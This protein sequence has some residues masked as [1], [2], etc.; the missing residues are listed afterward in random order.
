MIGGLDW[1]QAQPA[2][3]SALVLLAQAQ[4]LQLDRMQSRQP[5]L[6]F[7]ASNRGRGVPF[8]SSRWASNVHDTCIA[9]GLMRGTILLNIWLLAQA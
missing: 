4:S 7:A 2:P 9:L 6:H 3:C 5:A 1:R 8:A